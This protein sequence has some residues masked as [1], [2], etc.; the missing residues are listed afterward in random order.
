VTP[1]PLIAPPYRGNVLPPVEY[2]Q[3]YQGQQV[4]IRGDKARMDGLCP[5][6]PLPITLGCAI[7]VQEARGCIVVIANDDILK[8]TPWNYEMVL[9]HE[10]GHCQNWPGDHKGSRPA[11]PENMANY[12]AKAEPIPTPPTPATV[13]TM[14]DRVLP[15]IQS[16]PVPERGRRPSDMK[17]S[18]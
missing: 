3:Y 5:K 6:T 8:D 10:N 2:D 4:I 16:L 14:G 9:R 11:T 1:K 7:K 13:K 17:K 15:I 18:R 12:P